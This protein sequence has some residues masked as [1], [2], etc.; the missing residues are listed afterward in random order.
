M[1]LH[2]ELDAAVVFQGSLSFKFQSTFQLIDPIQS[3]AKFRTKE[4]IFISK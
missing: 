4:L 3:F 1:V 2:Q